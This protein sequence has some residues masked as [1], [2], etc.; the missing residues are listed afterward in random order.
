MSE[1]TSQII[2]LRLKVLDKR[3][4]AHTIHTPPERRMNILVIMEVLHLRRVSC[5]YCHSMMRYINRGIM[6]DD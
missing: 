4:P 5:R 3:M 6:R 1:T 2:P